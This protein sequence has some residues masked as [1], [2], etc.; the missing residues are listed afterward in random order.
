M[1]IIESLFFTT[2]YGAVESESVRNAEPSDAQLGAASQYSV[3]LEELEELEL[4]EDPRPRPPRPRP[5]M[6]SQPN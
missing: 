1:C 4:E 5:A 2:S 3:E 6:E